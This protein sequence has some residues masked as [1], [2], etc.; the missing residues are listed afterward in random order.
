MINGKTRKATAKC[1]FG[2]CDGE[3]LELFEGALGG[4]V[5]ET[6][7]GEKGYGWDKIFIPDGYTITR[8][9]MN[10]EDDQK[11]YLQIN[12]FAELK[13]FLVSRPNK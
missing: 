5:A 1:V 13:D 10:E 11:T 4:K 2:Y 7:A 8:A 12:P 9:Q 3:T 6:P